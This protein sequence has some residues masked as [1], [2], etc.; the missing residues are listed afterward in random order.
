MAPRLAAIGNSIGVGINVVLDILFITLFNWGMWGAS[1]ATGIGV[2]ATTLIL[3]AGT[4]RK[5]SGLHLWQCKPDVKELGKVIGIG[6]SSCLRE[7]AG[8]LIVLVINMILVA[9]PQAGELAVA[10]YGVIANFGTVILNTLSGVAS[11]MQPLISYNDGAGKITG[12]AV[13]FVPA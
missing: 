13:F 11:T 6:V 12:Y 8:A 9:L 1:L 7:L 4:F 3:F 10:A 5:G 2:A